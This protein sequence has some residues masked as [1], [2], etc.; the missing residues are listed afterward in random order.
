MC[1]LLLWFYFME[2][3]LTVVAYD[4]TN[5]GS[6]ANCAESWVRLLR[7]QYSKIDIFTKSTS[8]NVDG[9]GTIKIKD[10][11]WF[12]S[13]S[14][15]PIR[16]YLTFWLWKNR[17]RLALDGTTHD[18]MWWLTPMGIKNLPIWFKR[19]NAKRIVVGP[20]GG[21]SYVKR[22]SNNIPFNVKRFFYNVV[23]FMSRK[24]VL[25]FFRNTNILFL[26]SD[27]GTFDFFSSYDTF[28]ATWAPDCFPRKAVNKGKELMQS[29]TDVILPMRP[30][31]RKGLYNRDIY[32]NF[33]GYR[34]SS[35]YLVNVEDNVIIRKMSRVD[36]MNY[37]DT[38]SAALLPSEKDGLTST[39]CE[40][41]EK[42]IIPVALNNGTGYAYFL[43]KYCPELVSDFFEGTALDKLL[44]NRD[45]IL[46]KLKAGFEQEKRL[47]LNR[48]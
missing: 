14:N 47:I 45:E 15:S 48:L 28:E 4:Y 23:V 27:E 1:Y 8:G 16:F 2:K 10:S 26:C 38:F 17:L 13:H 22:T 37:L 40:L 12:L 30:N 29:A 9:I 24:K 44:Q 3:Q 25:L 35:F 21:L 11:Y 32:K 18:T 19:M 7:E 46:G 36:F 42:G 41:Y 31:W 33:H 39:F 43:K 20:I 6:E 5:G 34:V